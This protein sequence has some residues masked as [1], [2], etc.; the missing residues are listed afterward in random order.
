M[1]CRRVGKKGKLRVI[2]GAFIVG[3]GRW[4]RCRR[5]IDFVHDNR[6]EDSAGEYTAGPVFTSKAWLKKAAGRGVL[7]SPPGDALGP[8]RERG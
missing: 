3:D 1:W 6:F 5:W 2:A 8:I 4:G 7:S